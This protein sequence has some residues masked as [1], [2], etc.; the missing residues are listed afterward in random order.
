MSRKNVAELGRIF[1]AARWCLAG[2]MVAL[3]FVA[4]AQQDKSAPAKTSLTGR[5]EGPAKKSEKRVTGVT[6]VR[7]ER[8][9]PLPGK[10]ISSQ[11]AFPT[12]GVP[13]QGEAIP[14]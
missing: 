13:R 5:Y 9:G 1:V 10:I 3:C 7:T 6:C 8:E 12:R 2:L 14:I 11:G 4:Q